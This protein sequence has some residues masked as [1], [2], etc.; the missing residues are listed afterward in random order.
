MP[1]IFVPRTSDAL[2]SLIAGREQQRQQDFREKTVADELALKTQ[3]FGFQQEQARKE[4]EA[5]AL[6]TQRK[7]LKEELDRIQKQITNPKLAESNPDFFDRQV[8]RANEITSILSPGSQN[9]SGEQIRMN[10]PDWKKDNELDDLYIKEFGKNSPERKALLEETLSKYSEQPTRTGIIEGRLEDISTEEAEK[11]ELTSQK[12]LETF[13]TTEA[14]RK[15]KAKIEETTKAL[16]ERPP[17]GAVKT[18]TIGNLVYEKKGDKWDLVITGPEKKSKEADKVVRELNIL[19][20]ISKQAQREAEVEFGKA[21]PKS[22]YEPFLEEW[23]E[24]TEYDYEG[25]TGFIKDRTEELRKKAGVSDVVVDSVRGEVAGPPIPTALQGQSTAPQE[26]VDSF[27]AEGL[28]EQ[29]LT[30]GEIE[31]EGQYKG[32]YKVLRDGEVVNWYK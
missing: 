20:K 21:P 15:E 24:N 23:I 31:T 18:V 5:A 25:Y 8:S 14:I 28:T 3:Q 1:E 27:T 22:K 26:V 16:K 7:T 4:A 32:Y 6:S 2:R 29:G 10:L 11:R 9:L 13:K 17:K 19:E 30:L 12:E